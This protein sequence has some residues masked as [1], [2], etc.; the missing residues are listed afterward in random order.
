M[1]NS[2]RIINLNILKTSNKNINSKK[3]PQVSKLLIE[4]FENI[5]CIQFSTNE[6]LN[7]SIGYLE[8]IRII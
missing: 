4:V 8:I 3:F 6:Y 7:I 2:K 1:H 5:S